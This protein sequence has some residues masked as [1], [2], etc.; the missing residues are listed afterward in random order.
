MWKRQDFWK[1]H[2]QVAERMISAGRLSEAADEL[3]TALKFAR[4]T[5]SLKRELETLLIISVVQLQSNS[6]SLSATTQR[7]LEICEKYFGADSGYTA[8]ALLMRSCVKEICLT[9]EADVMIER[10]AKLFRE[11]G[12]LDSLV[13]R[14]DY[15]VYSQILANNFKHALATVERGLK[16]SREC[17]GETSSQVELMF[18]LYADLMMKLGKE[19]ELRRA[20][21]KNFPELMMQFALEHPDAHIFADRSPNSASTPRGS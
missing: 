11:Q 10:A 12:E 14:L 19:H 13:H 21:H 4:K 7:A 1:N 15:L 17:Y 8:R 16:Y 5:K 6:Q 20:L 18:H 3:R 9:S 2:I